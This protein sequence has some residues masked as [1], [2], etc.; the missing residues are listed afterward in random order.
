MGL[1]VVNE[2][3]KQHYLLFSAVSCKNFMHKT[4]PRMHTLCNN[5]HH[6]KI[7][8]AVVEVDEEAVEMV[9]EVEEE[10]VDVVVVEVRILHFSIS[11]FLSFS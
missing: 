7:E 3:E 1:A 4:N 10:V 9:E 6:E 2:Q 5:C 11:C 8:E